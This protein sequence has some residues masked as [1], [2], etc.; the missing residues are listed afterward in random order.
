M[1]APVEVGPPK[2]IERELGGC[3]EQEICDNNPNKQ[4]SY[5]LLSFTAI[6]RPWNKIKSVS[7]VFSELPIKG[8]LNFFFS[9]FLSRFFRAW[10]CN[11]SFWSTTTA[12][13]EGDRMRW[14]IAVGPLLFS[15]DRLEVLANFFLFFQTLFSFHMIA[16]LKE[17][18]R[19]V[20]R[21]FMTIS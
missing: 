20:G 17:M 21:I 2:E 15:S 9:F 10:K 8:N 11:A 6:F 5:F 14:G 3:G 12:I 16:A 13:G 1:S 4:S 7:A 19:I 18:I